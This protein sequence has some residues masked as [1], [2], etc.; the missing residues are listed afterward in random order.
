MFGEEAISS[1]RKAISVSPDNVPLRL[2]L[3]ETLLA[4]DR[5]DEAEAEFKSAL[6]L[7]P[8]NTQA[9]LGLAQLLATKEIK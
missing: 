7:S 5:G 2:H 6:G 1:L 8:K 4:M 9:S 3:A